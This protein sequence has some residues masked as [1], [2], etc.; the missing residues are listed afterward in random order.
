MV[1]NNYCILKSCK[2]IQQK[3]KGSFVHATTWMNPQ[4]IMPSEK[5]P[6]STI[7]FLLYNVLGNQ[8]L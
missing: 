1:K 7:R 2:T 6:Q 5:N 8:K 4:G 3:K